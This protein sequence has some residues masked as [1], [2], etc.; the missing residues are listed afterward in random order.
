MIVTNTQWE[1]SNALRKYPFSEDASL[2]DDAGAMLPLDIVTDMMLFAPDAEA[3]VTNV[4]ISP[5]MV[6]LAVLSGSQC[7]GV[8]VPRSSFEPYVPFQLSG[9]PG[10]GGY[11]TFGD[12]EWPSAGR[13]HRFSTSAQSK[14]DPHAV[15]KFPAPGVLKFVDDVSGEELSGDVVVS[16]PDIL[17]I[18]EVDGEIQLSMT[19]NGARQLTTPCNVGTDST[20]CGTPVI[21]TINGIA[22]DEDGAILLRFA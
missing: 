17:E 13:F 9:S 14:L 15:V 8:F 16:L 21:R 22:P 5:T 11:V 1:N 12:F 20:I 2:V 18:S 4:R 10:F 7:A 19:E 3:H 6:S